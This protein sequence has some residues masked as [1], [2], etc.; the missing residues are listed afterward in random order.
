MNVHRFLCMTFLAMALLPLNPLL[1]QTGEGHNASELDLKWGQPEWE[2]TTI[3]VHSVVHSITRSDKAGF[4]AGTSDGLF[5]SKDGYNW[6]PQRLA[7]GEVSVFALATDQNSLNKRSY[8]V[9]NA[10]LF[11]NQAAGNDTVWMRCGE[12]LGSLVILSIRAIGE[13]VIV[14]TASRGVY[15]SR[16]EGLHF[17]PWNEGLDGITV[18]T[19]WG[20][21]GSTFAA[22]DNGLYVRETRGPFWQRVDAGFACTNISGVVWWNYQPIPIYCSTSCGTYRYRRDPPE[23]W[24]QFNVGLPATDITS[25]TTTGGYMFIGVWGYG[26]AGCATNTSTSWQM[27]GGAPGP[28]FP[29]FVYATDTEFLYCG[30]RGEG[31]WRCNIRGPMAV[32]PPGHAL[33][34]ETV[35]EASFPNPFRLSTTVRCTLANAG[36]MTVCVYDMLGRVVATLADGW[37]EQGTYNL[38]FNAQGLPGGTYLCRLA[39]A[40]VVRHLR[41]MVLQ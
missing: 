2:Q 21:V 5:R 6:T 8:A 7:E 40:G 13:K 36:P 31:L 18:R 19:I 39:G 35:L 11:R 25:L 17:V 20:G 38:S 22:T 34:V 12:E 4:L 41:L 30:T 1:A 3:P 9:T 14:G 27:V 32:D 15:L 28:K 24:E 29:A 16:D 37:Y 33:P 26:V 23:G 10:G